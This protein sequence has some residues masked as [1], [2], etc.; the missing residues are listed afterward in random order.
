MQI[1]RFIFV[2]TE[3]KGI[4]DLEGK[5]PVINQI[6]EKFNNRKN[7]RIFSTNIT[8]KKNKNL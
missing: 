1:F 7:Q 5:T 3:R 2:Y 4:R 8:V 6:T